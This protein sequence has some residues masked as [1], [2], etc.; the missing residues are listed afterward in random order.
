MPVEIAGA[1]YFA[2]AEVAKALGVTRQTVWRWGA[3]G[4][5]PAGHRYRDRQLVFTRTE[6]DEIRKF[7]D[8]IE[9]VSRKR[10]RDVGAAKEV[11]DR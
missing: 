3:D 2:A 1:E 10:S 5:I 4:R 11:G 7:A 6:F 9:P 8:R